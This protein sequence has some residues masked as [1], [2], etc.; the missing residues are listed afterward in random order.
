MSSFHL[1]GA[2]LCGFG[3]VCAVIASS[4]DVTGLK[5][6]NKVNLCRDKCKVKSAYEPSGPSGQCLSPVSMA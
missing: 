3:V 1:V 6:L 4:L 2:I 5:Q